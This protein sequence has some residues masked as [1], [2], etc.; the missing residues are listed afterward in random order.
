MLS[1]R[2]SLARPGVDIVSNGSGSHHQLRKLEQ[3]LSLMQSATAK[4]GGVYMYANQQGCDGGRLYF[5]GCACG[6]R[7]C[8]AGR[9]AAAAHAWAGARVPCTLHPH[10]PPTQHAPSTPAPVGL[11]P[12][13][14]VNG[15][16]VAQGGQ[17]SLRDVE[18]VTAA[19]DLDAVVSHRN[20]VSSLRDHAAGTAALP[21]VG[22]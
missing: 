2:P 5:D 14:M 17:F 1:P 15:S 10:K 18:V 19:V 8:W 6:E 4:C 3:R 11:T 12:A 22:E 16:M 7:R 20:A 9:H 21:I 13:V